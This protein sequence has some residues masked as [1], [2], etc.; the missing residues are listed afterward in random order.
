MHVP[1][2]LDGFILFPVQQVMKTIQN[3]VQKNMIT[4]PILD[5]AAAVGCLTHWSFLPIK[6]LLSVLFP[7]SFS[8]SASVLLHVPKQFH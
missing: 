8:L 1:L 2:H 7:P 4:V 3:K 6:V 5:V